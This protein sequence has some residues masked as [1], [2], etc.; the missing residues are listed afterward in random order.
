MRQADHEAVY[1]GR[2]VRVFRRRAG[3]EALVYP[4]PELAGVPTEVRLSR[5]FRPHLALVP[6][7]A[8][9]HLAGPPTSAIVEE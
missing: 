4:G 8:V 2:L 9:W 6:I 5:A 7:A 1:R 3:V